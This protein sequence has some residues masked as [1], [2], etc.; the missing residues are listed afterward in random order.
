MDAAEVGKQI[1]T[2]GKEKGTNQTWPTLSTLSN[3]M[4]MAYYGNPHSVIVHVQV[5]GDGYRVMVVQSFNE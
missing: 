1:G 2:A 3:L 4:S 5:I